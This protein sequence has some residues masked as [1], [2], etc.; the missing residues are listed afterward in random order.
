MSKNAGIRVAIGGLIVYLILAGVCAAT[1][2]LDH[3]GMF[4]AGAAIWI[5]AI[6]VWATQ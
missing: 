2:D 1:G 3:A 5:A 6:F 4:A